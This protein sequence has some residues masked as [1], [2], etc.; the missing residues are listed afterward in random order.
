M[1]YSAE[2]FRLEQV[3]GGWMISYPVNSFRM[4]IE[5]SRQLTDADTLKLIYVGKPYIPITDVMDPSYSI[6]KVFEEF[7]AFQT[8]KNRGNIFERLREEGDH[9]VF[10]VLPALPDAEIQVYDT[11]LVSCAIDLFQSTVGIHIGSLIVNGNAVPEP[12]REEPAPF[13]LDDETRAFIIQEALSRE[14]F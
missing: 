14:D 2:D 5:Q 9:Y 6:D 10:E 7:D 12:L 1:M 3:G 13:V 8:L 4:S 11:M